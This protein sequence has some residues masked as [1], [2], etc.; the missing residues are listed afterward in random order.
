MYIK[1]TMGLLLVVGI[2]LG[3][4][5]YFIK[6]KVSSTIPVGILFSLSGTMKHLESQAKDAMLLAID[7]INKKGGVLGKKIEAIVVDG[8]TDDEVFREEAE[9]LIRDK[10][11]P[12]LFGC[13]TSSS[14][15]QVKEIVEKHNHLLLYPVQ[16]EGLE[17]S[18]NIIYLG[19]TSNQQSIPAITWA[20]NN[21]GKRFFFVGSDFIYPRAIHEI[22]KEV[23]TSLGGMIVGEEYIPMNS[24]N[25]SPIIQ[26]IIEAKPEVIINNIVTTIANIPFFKQLRAV[27]ITPERIPTITCSFSELMLQH[28]EVETMIGD[29]SVS[30]YFQSIDRGVNRDFI[31]KFKA[32]FGKDR[33]VNDMME[34]SYFAVHL[35]AQ[36]VG[37][38]GTFE[39]DRVRSHMKNQ[40]FN[41]PEGIVTISPQYMQTWKTIYIAKIQSNGQYNIIFDSGQAISPISYPTFYRSKE[42]WNQFLLS[43]YKKWGNKWSA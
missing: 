16:F 25:V 40:S 19:G 2:L 38:I 12:V 35:W 39:V 3:L 37:E 1:R 11:V 27:G 5:L 31:K 42:Q 30:N 21:L 7:E 17:E 26:K 28:F 41:A 14:R 8:K 32:L 20:F 15:K 10:R 22:M 43:L 24:D 9:M 18:P 29:Y 33:L 4:T 34:A 6:N 13:W 36:T 23:L